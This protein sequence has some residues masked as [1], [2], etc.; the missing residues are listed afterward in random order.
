MILQ[1]INAASRRVHLQAYVFTD[2]AIAR[3]L[4]SAYRRNLEVIVL[5][6]KDQRHDRYSVAPELVQAGLK[7]MFDDRPQIAHNKTIIIDPDDPDP[8]VETGSYNFSYSAE[9]RNAENALLVRD[10]PALATAYE[11]YFQA[12][13]AAS[14]PW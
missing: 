9:R 7:V 14:D 13:L 4:E 8:V 6:D 11:Q 12:R 1:A 5:L 10:D 3:A 2:R